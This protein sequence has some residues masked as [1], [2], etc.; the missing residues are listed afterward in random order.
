[1]NKKSGFQRLVERKNAVF[2]PYL[3][4]VLAQIKE[5]KDNAKQD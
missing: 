3:P 4:I 5:F 1:M 2:K